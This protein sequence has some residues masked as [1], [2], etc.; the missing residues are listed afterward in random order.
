LVELGRRSDGLCFN[1]NAPNAG[2]S[3]NH[4]HVHAWV[5]EA[6]YPVQLCA[7]A[8][9]APSVRGDEG[10]PIGRALGC[11][12]RLDIVSGYAAT[13][14]RVRGGSVT[15]AGAAV[16]AL[17]RAVPVHNVAACG[18]DVFVFLREPGT[19]LWA[20]GGCTAAGGEGRGTR[21]SRAD[22][23]APEISGTEMP[24]EARAVGLKLGAA[25]LLGRFVV[26]TPAQYKLAARAGAVK[27]ALWQ[28]RWRGDLRALLD[29]IEVADE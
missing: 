2:A 17:V 21:A 26:D 16:H 28:T 7:Q 15:A 18:A 22:G 29:G 11:G 1:F 14:V 13:C 19:E 10:E 9:A 20:L 23:G 3:Q 24:G 4:I 5:Q 12:T 27:A 8:P 6:P 25:Q